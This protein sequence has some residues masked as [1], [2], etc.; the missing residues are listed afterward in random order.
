MSNNEQPPPVNESQH[1]WST[2]KIISVLV[3]LVMLGISIILYNKGSQFLLTLRSVDVSRGLITFLVAITTVA[4]ALIATLYAIVSDAKDLK[5]R[6][7]FIKDI[8]TV[9][10]GVLGTVV[11]YYFGSADTGG[12]IIQLAE[13]RFRSGQLLTH[14]SGG[15]EPFRFTVTYK[16]QD[17]KSRVQKISKDGW[18]IESLTP[19]PGKSEEVT[20][21]TTDAK[22]R[23]TSRSSL[24]LEMENQSESPPPDA[25]KAASGGIPASVT[26]SVPK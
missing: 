23:R 22:G 21:E 15:M 13:I 14:V 20:V 3:S 2:T 4:L 16:S 10:V 5:E 18:I 26:N 11:G 1:F 24:Y 8:F 9:L 19:V 7:V 25:A 12:Q 17:A 6:F